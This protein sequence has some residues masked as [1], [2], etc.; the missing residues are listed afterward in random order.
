MYTTPKNTNYYSN[1]FTDPGMGIWTQSLFH[2]GPLPQW[3][4]S[5]GRKHAIQADRIENVLKK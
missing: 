4:D 2:R 5:T 1:N 3:L